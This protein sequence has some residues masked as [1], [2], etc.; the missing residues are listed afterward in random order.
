MILSFFLTSVFGWGNAHCFGEDPA[1][2]KRVVKTDH[3]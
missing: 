1:E 3:Y 2:I